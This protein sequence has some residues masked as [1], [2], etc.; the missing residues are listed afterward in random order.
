MR[1][2]KIQVEKISPF[3]LNR[4]S[5]HNVRYQ[6]CLNGSSLPDNMAVIAVDKKYL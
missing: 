2:H 3:L 1:L 4:Y 5:V 6:H